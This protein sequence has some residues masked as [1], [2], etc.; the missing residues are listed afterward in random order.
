MR[1]PIL[2]LWKKW[3]QE[4]PPLWKEFPLFESPQQNISKAAGQTQTGSIPWLRDLV[5]IGA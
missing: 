1:V 4:L 2:E 3:V 5:Y